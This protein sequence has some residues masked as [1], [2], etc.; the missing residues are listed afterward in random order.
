MSD[1]ELLEELDMET[2]PRSRGV[3]P[4]IVLGL[5][6]V[7]FALGF[8]AGGWTATPSEVEAP[9]AAVVAEEV[10]PAV[11][12]AAEPEAAEAPPVASTEPPRPA[13]PRTARP[14]P[15]AAEPPA[16]PAEAPSSDEAPKAT[17]R[18]RPPPPA[19]TLRSG[20]RSG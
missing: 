5:L 20:V 7:T 3:A 6:A 12:A 17:L 9:V 8:V 16:A 10:A 1:D 4:P 15:A 18:S 19:A 13:R 14:R 11:P 2:P